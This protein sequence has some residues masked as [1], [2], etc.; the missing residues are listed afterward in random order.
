[1]R[2]TILGVH[3]NTGVL[4]GDDQRRFDFPLSEWRS[5]GTPVAGQIVD[6]VEEGGQ[7]GGVFAV[8]GA[9]VRGGG[10]SN[11]F[12]LSAIAVACLLL[13]FIVPVL[14]TIAAFVLGVVASSQAQAEHDENA[15]LMARIAWIGALVLMGLGI[16][17][18]LVVF[19]FIGTM[20]YAG[21]MHGWDF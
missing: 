11:S 3:G 17:V 14:P 2:G 1:M 9:G 4:V 21:F 5:P 12:V 19:A 16:L 20:G 8:P 13:G 10:H 18:M 6:F 7:A 15:L